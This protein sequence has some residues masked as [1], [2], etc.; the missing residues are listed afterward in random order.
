MPH[1]L[2]HP[3]EWNDDFVATTESSIHFV[4]YVPPLTR[5]PLRLRVNNGPPVAP[6][7][8]VLSR[9]G[10]VI[11]LDGEGSDSGCLSDK[12]L[13]AA[14]RTVVAQLRQLIGVQDLPY[15]GLLEGIE[16]ETVFAD[17]GIARRA[18]A[19]SMVCT[20]TFATNRKWRR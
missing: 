2:P 6:R 3:N 9:T 17:S 5:T 8:Y 19:R 15:T 18:R 13:D 11:L 14:M 16:I 1:A 4:F 20:T 7:A 12:E 10:G